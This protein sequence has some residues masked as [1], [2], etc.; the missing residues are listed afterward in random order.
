MRTGEDQR[1]DLMKEL[2]IRPNLITTFYFMNIF[3][4]IMAGDW[5]HRTKQDGQD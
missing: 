1:S 5:A 2:K 3:M 4:G